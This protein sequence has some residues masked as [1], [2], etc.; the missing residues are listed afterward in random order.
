M[1]NN[2]SEFYEDLINNETNYVRRHDDER[3]YFMPKGRAEDPKKDIGPISLELACA[4]ELL[5]GNF[6]EAK[7]KE[8]L[9]KIGSR[10]KIEIEGRQP[11][12]PGEQ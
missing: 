7:K 10:D 12:Q 3:P 2:F 6:E 11:K 4:V 5:E 8:H 9:I 1:Y